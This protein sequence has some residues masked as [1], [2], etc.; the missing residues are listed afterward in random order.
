VPAGSY[1]NVPDD[2]SQFEPGSWS[3]V[4]VICCA[5]WCTGMAVAFPKVLI[6]SHLTESAIDPANQRRDCESLQPS[7]AFMPDCQL[8]MLK[9]MNFLCMPTASARTK[10]MALLRMEVV[11]RSISCRGA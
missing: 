4:F 11:N 2:A 1:L 8:A 7:P 9:A 6:C 3:K 10:Q 5:H